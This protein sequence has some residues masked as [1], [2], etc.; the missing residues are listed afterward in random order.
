MPALR[1]FRSLL[2][3]VT[4]PPIA[5]ARTRGRLA[6]VPAEHTRQEFNFLNY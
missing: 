3:L 2:P 6:G 5:P 1:A 4:D